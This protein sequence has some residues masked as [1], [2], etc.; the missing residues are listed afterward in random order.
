MKRL[1]S[2]LLVLCLIPAAALAELSSFREV[3]SFILRFVEPMGDPRV[4]LSG[5]IIDIYNVKT[6]HWDM[7]VAVDEK[8][9]PNSIYYD[10]PY[11]IAHFRLHVDS[12][13]F[14]VGDYVEVRGTINFMYSSPLIPFV[15]V[16]TIND[17]DDF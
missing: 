11:F 6:N 2:L 12:V 17:S 10:R 1:F 15:Q 7:K 8:D 9:A 3:N 14:S 5:E 4:R 16:D 13:P